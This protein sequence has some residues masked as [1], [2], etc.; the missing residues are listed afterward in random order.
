MLKK[1]LGETALYGLSSMVG[2]TLNFLLVA[3]YTHEIY[4]FEPTQY[5]EMSILYAYTAFLNVLFTY[6][7]ETAYF[8]Y[9]HKNAKP[10]E[11]Y[12][13]ILSYL[14]VSTAIFT[15]LIILFSD[16]L[17]SLLNYPARGNFIRWIAIILAVDTIL[18]LVYARLRFEK[19]AW[20][21]VSTKVGNI[22]L[23]I[24]L[25]V[26]FLV[27]CKVWAGNSWIDSWYQPAMGVGYVFLANLIANLLNFVWLY[28]SFIDFRFRFM[29]REFAPLLWYGYPLA[30]MGLAGVASQMLDRI[31]LQYYLPT[32]YYVGHSTKE[33][34]GIYGACIKLT[35]FMS[36]AIQSFKYAAE[37]FFFSQ[38]EDKKSPLVFAQVMHYFV[39]ICV[40]FWLAI[41]LNLYWIKA[42][43]IRNPVYHEGVGIVPILLLANLLL[44]IYYNFS[45]WFKLT[46]R[47][48]Y[49]TWL[50]IGGA[51]VTWVGN[52][53]FI[54][55]FG[56]MAC[57]WVT[58]VSYGGMAFVCYAL[59]QRHY[60]V[61]YRI[62][63]M[64]LHLL[65]GSLI[66]M[67]S[68][69]LPAEWG[70]WLLL[71]NMGLFAVYLFFVFITEMKAWKKIGFVK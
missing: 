68:L 3:L 53:L 35:I 64:L 70:M 26:F 66:V 14:L 56:Y 46:D 19:K 33:A 50:S 49:G 62:G 51:L 55:V 60:P 12:N 13:L 34:V 42:V 61:P 52:V 1:L 37:P 28:R 65:L 69:Q 24:G 27:V 36:L 10:I 8:R 20:L 71:P 5:A 11:V 48:H 7:M 22:V 44:G 21:F 63:Q 32:G 17:A 45:F 39:I 16:G 40:M 41:S 30:L 4:G 31:L 9:A 23:T 25:N 47:T 59:G 67:A 2:R 18:S 15:G 6:G 43:F 29:W 54:P 58:L 38:A 57:A